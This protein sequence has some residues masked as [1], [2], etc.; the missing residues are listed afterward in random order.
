MMTTTT[1][2]LAT[3]LL[4]AA[5]CLSAMKDIIVDAMYAEDAGVLDFVV[6]TAGHGPFTE[7]YPFI[8]EQTPMLLTGGYDDDENSN[9]IDRS[10]SCFLAARRQSD[11]ELKWRRKICS[12]TEQA[13]SGTTGRYDLA[14]DSTTTDIQKVFTV[15]GLGVVRAW[16]L[17]DG[18]LLWDT[19]VQQ[20]ES[21]ISKPRVWTVPVTK[22]DGGQLVAVTASEDLVILDATSGDVYDTI[23]GLHAIHGGNLKSGE[24]L[25]WLSIFASGQQ[26]EFQA[27]LAVTK[28]GLVHNG[29]NLYFAEIEI[30]NDKPKSVKSLNHV[31]AAFVADS[32]H[33]QSA[34]NDGGMYGLALTASKTGMV[35]FSLGH[36]KNHFEEFSASQLSPKWSTLTAVDGTDM[37]SLIR[38]RGKESIESETT[39][40]LYS[41]SGGEAQR[42]DESSDM[43]YFATTV[44]PQADLMISLGDGLVKV[45][46]FNSAGKL[47]VLSTTGDIYV[48]DG[49][50]VAVFTSVSCTAKSASV[51]LQTQRGSTAQLSFL[52][53][54][55][56]VNIH[57]DWT[58]EEG[59][60]SVSSVVVLDATHL[61]FDDLVEEQDVVAHKLSLSGRLTSQWNQITGLVSGGNTID[62]AVSF[63]VRDHLFGFVKV[64]ALLSP[65]AHRIWGLNTSGGS[66][67]GTIRW[68]VD[69][70][71]D[72]K[73]HTMVHGTTNSPTAL[74][75]INGGT[76]SREILVL[77]ATSHSVEWMCIDGTNGA[78][79]TQGSVE[80]FSSIVQVLPL[81]GP[82]TGGCRQASLIL[83]ED[84]S[85]SVIPYDAETIDL[86][87][88]HL[89]KTQN[90][91]FAH[92][93]DKSTQK[94]ESYQVIFADG[95]SKFE[96]RP[97]GMTSFSGEEIV[98][99]AYPIRHEAVQS[100]STILGDDSLLLKYI[101]PHLAVVLTMVSDEENQS[102]TLM[103]T[104]LQEQG[105]KKPRKPAGVGTPDPNT[106][107]AKDQKVPNMFVNL[108]DT[109][110]GR[111]LYR[112][113]HAE[114][115]RNRKMSVVITENWV[116]YTFVNKIT[117][118]TEIGVLT[119]H[120]GMIDKKGLTFFSTPE[121]TSSF[122]SLDAR[123]SKPVVLSKTYAFSKAV[124]A[125]GVTSTRQGISSQNILLAGADGSLTALPRLML[126]TRRPM[127]EA[128]PNEKKE[129]LL[130]YRELIPAV[131]LQSLT[132]NRTLE[133]FS[134]VIASDT[135]LESQSLVIGFGGPD[136]FFVRTSPT[137]GFD[138]LPETFNK[139]LVALVTVGIVAAFIVVQRMASRKAVKMG[140]L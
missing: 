40:S 58:A 86:V 49:D 79:N 36:G 13:G 75:G 104:N 93:I 100:M 31:R 118:R 42:W 85:L 107:P 70:P 3:A 28:G 61:G 97:V 54:G 71:K 52:L 60:S 29:A 106:D 59:L 68:S 95:K 55:D 41:I 87:K 129:G 140:W 35:H 1:R 103:A 130:P 38:V 72:A 110:S 22:E 11:G 4:A 115:D 16:S 112:T 5:L 83:H 65:L 12:S 51:L 126:E 26:N 46:R 84:L 99:V 136:L 125:L 21:A 111:L 73:W 80:V 74:H 82:S 14:V 45:N 96:A 33:I 23:R 9:V 62:G 67:R 128:K 117:R 39:M 69:L 44:C 15:D 27:L 32:L 30:G 92:K 17:D 88:K 108:V 18:A 6:T 48:P 19:I 120:E 131:P 127:G 124:S 123:E 101:N 81:Y 78:V 114:V 109:V 138:L 77:S 121:Q 2:S 50:S 90:G 94:L 63:S 116:V 133:P 24:N 34:S 139:V 43:T 102:I 25:Q 37:P 10:P 7:V 137:K 66:H 20:D 98:E 57:V 91:F 119:L 56:S 113:S 135:S 53:E 122:S 134:H 89:A 8:S 105:G 132:Y 64:A 76:H 47:S